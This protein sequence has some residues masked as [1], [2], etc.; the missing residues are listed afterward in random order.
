[1]TAQAALAR[2][3]ACNEFRLGTGGRGM[4]P[5]V[6]TFIPSFCR[7][8]VGVRTVRAEINICACSAKLSQHRLVL[9]A[10]R[11]DKLQQSKKT[12]SARRDKSQP[13]LKHIDVMLAYEGHHT[14][15]GSMFSGPKLLNDSTNISKYP[16]IA[17]FVIQLFYSR[18][19][20]CF[21]HVYGQREHS[22]CSFLVTRYEYCWYALLCVPCNGNHQCALRRLQVQT[23]L[24]TPFALQPWP[25]CF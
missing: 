23:N 6:G 12:P 16:I 15:D 21:V 20:K 3:I 10:T 1:M 24:I 22:I 19:M 5:E 17:S 18:A 13:R 7:T 2:P 25:V 11:R 14:S 9:I 4:P 8:T